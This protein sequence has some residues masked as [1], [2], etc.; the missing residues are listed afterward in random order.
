MRA[1]LHEAFRDRRVVLAGG[2]GRGID[3]WR[4]GVRRARSRALPGARCRPGHRAVAVRARCRC[5]R[6]GPAR[7]TRCR[8]RASRRRS[9]VPRSAA[10]VRRTTLARFDPQGD[11]LVL[12]P[13]FAALY[14]LAG[15]PAYGG[16]R[17]EWVALEDKTVTDA[18]F[19]AAAVAAPPFEIVPAERRAL[20][21]AARRVDCGA[22]TVWAGDA[23]QGF[24]GST[25]YVHWVVDT[26]DAGS[27]IAQLASRPAGPGRRVRRGDPVQCARV[28]HRRRDR[29]V[30]ARRVDG[31]ARRARPRFRFAGAGTIWD[32]PATD[33]AEIRAAAGRVGA[34]LREQVGF[35]G[36]YTVDGILSG[37]LGRQRV[38]SALRSRAAIHARPRLPDRPRSLAS[39]RDRG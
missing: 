21:A 23:Q 30:P 24:N 33:R 3:R 22:G 2:P 31:A 19:A 38:Q 25:A 34:R 18:L 9:P 12:P 15:R 16:R 14:E 4:R 11:A 20:V 37:R 39:R 1:V 35:R 29:R 36:A 17:A 5:R 28:R 13:P 26:D 10:A 7:G 32:P 8:G 27:R 6:M